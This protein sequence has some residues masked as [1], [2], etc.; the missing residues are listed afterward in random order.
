L[1]LRKSV[2]VW[3]FLPQVDAATSTSDVTLSRADA[4]TMTDECFLASLH[5]QTTKSSN[6]IT[7]EHAY[8]RSDL[9]VTSTPVKPRSIN[10]NNTASPVTKISTDDEPS[11]YYDYDDPS[12]EPNDDE[13]IMSTDISSTVYTERNYV[14]ESK[15]IVFEQNMA[16]LFKFCLLCGANVLEKETEFRGSLCKVI[17]LLAIYS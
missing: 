2:G 4:M 9:Q 16:P 12:Y 3:A 13:D 1:P 17:Y 6:T 10:L 15:F 7:F 11:E 14:T 5:E 8:S